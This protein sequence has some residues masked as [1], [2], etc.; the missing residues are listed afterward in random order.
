[1]LERFVGPNWSGPSPIRVTGSEADGRSPTRLRGPNYI[2]PDVPIHVT[3]R[4]DQ[5]S[6]RRLASDEPPFSGAGSTDLAR[7]PTRWESKRCWTSSTR[8]RRLANTF[9]TCDFI[10][11]TRLCWVFAVGSTH[12]W[13]QRRER[14]PDGGGGWRR[15]E[16]AYTVWFGSLTFCLANR[17]SFVASWR[18]SRSWG[19]SWLAF[20]WV[21]T[22]EI[23]LSLVVI[24]APRGKFDP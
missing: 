4:R 18:W 19:L 2:Q 15:R 20:F 14:E 8:G 16:A 3:S 21:K 22:N 23:C 10:F 24:W 9:P 13:I 12:G 1:M 6:L 17:T 11:L 5:S 7:V